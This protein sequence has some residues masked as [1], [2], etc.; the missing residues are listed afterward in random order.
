MAY[1][2]LE[3]LTRRFGPTV[4]VDGVDLD[5]ER[6]ELVT[7]LGP[8]GCGKTTTL[9]L[10]A[11]LLAPDAG[12]IWLDGERLTRVPA[13]DRAMGMVFQSGALFPNMTAAENVGFPLRLQRLPA[14]QRRR[15]VEE[16]L[17]LVGL[18]GLADRYPHQ[19]SGGQ[20]QRVG[21]GRALA[22]AP[23]VLLL[24]EPLSALDAPVRRA[25]I[26]ELRRLQQTLGIT[27]LYV[28]H[29][30]EEA[31]GLSDRVAVLDRGRVV[32]VG[33]PER[34][35]GAP[36]SAFVAR[37][38]GV[39]N[40]LDGRVVAAAPP[41]V[42]AGGLRLPVLDLRGARPG[43]AVRVTLRPEDVRLSTTTA[44]SWRG[45]VVVKTFLGALTRLDVD[46][47]GVRLRVDLPSPDAAR[48]AARQ[49]VGL[50]PIA[51]GRVIEVGPV[52]RS[53]ADPAPHARDHASC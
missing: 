12:D 45:V 14:A 33:S 41:V 47:G 36:Q 51:P 9:R 35:Y 7:L 40:V 34:L 42:E 39:T 48:L 2:R 27:A 8:S 30:Q 23:R 46:V 18:T 17:T 37:F 32:E 26:V 20:Q 22:R 16:I 28:T 10:V 6:G 5:V 25:L 15:R 49:E 3:R 43:D 13:P 29:D 50:A 4:A 24:D 38:I 11:G 31:L 19:L 53:P 1:L 21:I 44:A 52:A